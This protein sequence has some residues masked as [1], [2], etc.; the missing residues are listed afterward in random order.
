MQKKIFI[1]YSHKDESYKEQLDEHL[2]LLERNNFVST[3]HDRK[4]VGSDQWKDKILS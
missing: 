2:T 3:W 4:I 1:S